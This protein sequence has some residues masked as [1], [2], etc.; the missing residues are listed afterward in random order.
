MTDRQLRRRLT[1]PPNAA[2]LHVGLGIAFILLVQLNYVIAPRL[3][4]LYKL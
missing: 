2:N 1:R 3:P 4:I